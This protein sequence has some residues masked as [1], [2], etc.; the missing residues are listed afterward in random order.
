MRTS[1]F[2]AVVAISAAL[3]AGIPATAAVAGV[4]RLPGPHA[5][6]APAAAGHA[7]A[8][9]TGSAAAAA[10]AAVFPGVAADG[11]SV[12]A[13]DQADSRTLD[14]TIS[15]PAAGTSVGVELLLPPGWSASTTTTWP[16]LYMLHGCCD[17]FNGWSQ[18][19]NIADQTAGAPVI[20]AEPD[21]GPVGFYSNWFNGGAGGEGFE[22]FTA[23]ELPQI[24]ASG[25]HASG[26]AAIAGASTGGGAALFIAAHN[27]G[28]FRAVA[29]YSGLDCTELPQSIATIDAA[30]MRANVN[31]DNLWGSPTAQR[32]IWQQHDPC[33]LARQF[34]GMQVF[35]ST[36]SGFTASGQQTM[37]AAGIG[38]NILE[39]DVATGVQTLATTLK[40]DGIP[41]TSDFYQGGCHD[42]PFWQTA[43][44][45]S[46]P[47]L[48]S[49]L[50]I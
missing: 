46:W 21:G 10:P 15:S 12:T 9:G 42:W 4:F 32:S 30:M 11:A 47:M 22:T 6:T 34:S 35:L 38:G 28:A 45:K 33:A 37:C 24:L 8:T 5:I 14:I 31:P 44:A 18:N 2:A 50:G 26:V 39:S 40:A 41:F 36:G 27:P 25:F 16:V 13:E 20:I 29:S 19:T 7:T 17:P 23:T 48:Q 3:T 43:F 49:A 1:R